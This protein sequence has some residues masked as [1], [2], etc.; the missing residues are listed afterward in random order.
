MRRKQAEKANGV[1]PILVVQTLKPNSERSRA[2]AAALWWTSPHTPALKETM[3]HA[4]FDGNVHCA[5]SDAPVSRDA[6]WS[7]L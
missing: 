5:L 4:A 3:A 2:Q 7:S 6:L 1:P